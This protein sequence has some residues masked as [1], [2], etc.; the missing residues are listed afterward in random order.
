MRSMSF[1]LVVGE[2]LVDVVS[3]AGAPTTAYVGGSALNAAVALRRLG[4]E[5]RFATC[6]ADDSYGEMIR[7]R[8]SAEGVE[9]AAE[10]GTVERTA[11]ARATVGADGSASYT[12]DLAWR[13]G[14]VDL[15]SPPAVVTVGSLGSVLEPG[16]DDVHRL[17]VGLRDSWAKVK[18]R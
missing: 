4:R 8:L 2:S 1:A 11:S 7:S 10:P 9:L 14:P 3:R 15:P 17:A 5:V 6:F 16:A 13:L 18:E 12:F